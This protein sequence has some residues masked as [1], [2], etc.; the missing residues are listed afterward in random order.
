[1]PRCR[2]HRCP[3]SDGIETPQQELHSP[4][5][6]FRASCSTDHDNSTACFVV[7]YPPSLVHW[8]CLSFL[9]R[10]MPP[11]S[12]GRPCTGQSAAWKFCPH[13]HQHLVR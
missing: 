3:W 13:R 6:H 1:M 8:V 10:P 9:P 11:I 12:Q 4:T 2:E 5:L 7:F